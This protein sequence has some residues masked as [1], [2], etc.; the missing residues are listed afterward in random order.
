MKRRSP[1]GDRLVV[2]PYAN[3]MVRLVPADATRAGTAAE[4]PT[5][6]NGQA[7]IRP[8][9]NGA[10]RAGVGARVALVGSCRATA[11]DDATKDAG[12]HTANAS[13]VTVA[14]G[15]VLGITD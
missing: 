11:D 14:H 12:E 5:R 1:C 15:A 9:A 2:L 4:Y 13:A 7:E 3:V 8:I 10:I 6:W